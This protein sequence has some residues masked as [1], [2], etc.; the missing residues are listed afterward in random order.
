M[1][2]T[3]L[4]T[5]IYSIVLLLMFS[6]K[7]TIVESENEYTG[8]AIWPLAVDNSW[9]YNNE[10][11]EYTLSISGSMKKNGKTWYYLYENNPES[12]MFR[13]NEDGLWSFENG[14][15]VLFWKYPAVEGDIFSED[16]T[17]DELRGYM[18]CVRTNITYGQYENCYLYKYIPEPYTGTYNS[19]YL[20]PDI[21]IVKQTYFENGVVLY[22]DELISYNLN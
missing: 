13:N 2:T 20:K 21:G 16:W 18:L 4:K 17:D 8:S 22:S 10:G 7:K 14:E 5:F 11:G 15:E 3:L 1:K 6:C 12:A 19:Y 9:T